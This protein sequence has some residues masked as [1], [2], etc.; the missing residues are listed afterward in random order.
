M[1][2][3]KYTINRLDETSR[4]RLGEVVRFCIV[5]VIAVVIQYAVYQLLLPYMHPTLGNTIAYLVSFLFNYI[6]STRFTFRV[7]STARRGIGFALSHLVNYLMQTMLLALFL[8]LGVEKQL[9]IIPVMAIC[10]PMNFVLV[11]YFLTKQS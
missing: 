3:K 9:A 11:R 7:K 4:Q 10:V 6:A 1:S 8:W 2:H 5:G